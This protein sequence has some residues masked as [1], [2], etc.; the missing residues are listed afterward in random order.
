M[1]PVMIE[2]TS[3]VTLMRQDTRKAQ[4]GVG[5]KLEADIS[6]IKILSNTQAK[7]SRR[8]MIDGKDKTSR[9]KKAA[10]QMS[11]QFRSSL[12]G[13]MSE[14]ARSSMEQSKYQ[15]VISDLHPISKLPSMLKNFNR[16]ANKFITTQ[17]D[18]PSL[19]KAEMMLR[20]ETLGVLSMGNMNRRQKAYLE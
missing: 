8:N 1:S 7:N 2:S 9:Q 3:V 18:D 5:E 6:N 15:T 16:D 19:I 10:M 4:A 12:G 20:K 14:L 13:E 11:N 17:H